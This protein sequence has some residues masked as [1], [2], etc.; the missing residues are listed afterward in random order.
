[1]T[2]IALGKFAKVAA[3]LV[4]GVTAFTMARN[5][6]PDELIHLAD[7]LRV[8]PG[9]RY[10]H[11]AIQSVAGVS[12]RK[13]EEVSLGTFVYA[14]LFAT[15]GIGLWLQKRWAEFFTIAITVSFIPLEIYE[16]ARHVSAGK[17]IA[18]VLN[19]AALVY[20]VVRVVYL[21]KKKDRKAGAAA[22]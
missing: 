17:I 16:I 5:G 6:A 12:P 3:L 1:M 19:V 20:L 10:L 14:A 22:S 21:D 15:E 7:S 18:L 4:I 2:L 13:L 9:N 11:R 8:D